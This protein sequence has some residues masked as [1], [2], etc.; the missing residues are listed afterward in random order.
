MHYLVLYILIG[1]MVAGVTEQR[2]MVLGWGIA[3]LGLLVFVG[4]VLYY[5]AIF[6]A[7][8]LLF[9]GAWLI[10]RRLQNPGGVPAT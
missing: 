9:R 3:L 2:W 6:Y 8:Y 4:C 7:A 1:A 10:G 5:S